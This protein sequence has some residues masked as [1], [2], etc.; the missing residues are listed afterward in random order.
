MF[1]KWGRFRRHTPRAKAPICRRGERPKAKALGYPEATTKSLDG[2]YCS[3]ENGLNSSEEA[4]GVEGSVGIELVF[5]GLHE[6]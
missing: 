6:G 4:A 1:V 3:I 2:A 5:Y